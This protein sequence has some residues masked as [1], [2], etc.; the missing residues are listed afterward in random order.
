MS[1]VEFSFL[2]ELS[3]VTVGVPVKNEDGTIYAALLLHST[4][5]GMEQARRDGILILMF[6]MFTAL[7]LATGLSVLLARHFIKPLQTMSSVT[8]QIIEGDYQIHTGISQNDE[9]GMLAQNIDELSVRLSTV[10][11]ERKELDKMRQE[12][13]SN[14][15]HELRT[16]VTVI[17]GSLEVLEQGLVT[18]QEEVK[19]YYHQMF[20][21]V[22]CLQ[23][24][25][26]DLLE[27]S[28]LQNTSFRIEKVKMNL[29][30]AL[31]EA[32]RSMQRLAEK[33]NIVLKCIKDEFPFPFYGDY[34]R[35]RQMFAI[36]LDN[37]IKFSLPDQTVD[38]EMQIRQGE[39]VVVVTDYGKG[40]PEEEIPHIFERFH[41]ECSVQ[42]SSGSGLGLSIARQ[43][44]LRHDIKIVC[45]S[46]LNRGTSFRFTFHNS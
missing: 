37:A 11:L 17:K 14:I 45:E 40:I 12:F 16:P 39:C 6:C 9:I 33:K 24:L 46:R 20:T 4:I 27:L 21:D 28:R 25:V 41:K 43:I 10:D 35:I 31:A 2:P 42:N 36:I 29:P 7:I 23:R 32:V 30:D 19:E 22:S 3:T 1:L 38:I 34:G 26:D 5:D 15:S 8:E 44:A 13:V 18:G